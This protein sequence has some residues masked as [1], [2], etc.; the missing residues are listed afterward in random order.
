[1]LSQGKKEPVFRS[2][3]VQPAQFSNH[4]GKYKAR[5]FFFKY[6]FLEKRGRLIFEALRINFKTVPAVKCGSFLLK[7][8]K[9]PILPI[10]SSPIVSDQQMF[11]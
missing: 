6:C 9:H 4:Y 3:T 5:C 8:E 10:A 1:M 11:R 2:A 7:Q